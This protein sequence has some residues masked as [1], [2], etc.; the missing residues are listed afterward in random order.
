MSGLDGQ[1][2]S[3]TFDSLLTV[4]GLEP[5]TTVAKWVADGFGNRTQIKVSTDNTE[6]YNVTFNSAVVFGAGYSFDPVIPE[7]SGGTGY[8]S[9]HAAL[10]VYYP[11]A[12][13]NFDEENDPQG[14]DYLLMGDYN[15]SGLIKHIKLSTIATYAAAAVPIYS[16][17]TIAVSGQSDIVADLSTD[18]LTIVAGT[19]TVLTTDAST[20]TLTITSSGLGWTKL[21]AAS[22]ALSV[23]N[24][25]ICTNVGLTTLTLPATFAIGDIIKVVGAS[26]GLWRVAQNAGQQIHFSDLDSTLGATGYLEATNTRDSIELI[27]IT[28]NTELQVISSIGNITIN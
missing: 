16:F 24:G 28:A 26:S 18:T 7:A 23:N 21:S 11:Y 13:A 3:T 12:R 17:K 2:I 4:E 8:S 20:D 10:A 27:G 25:Y 5:L 19:G 14:V 6:M 9:V 15:N 22:Q 1:A